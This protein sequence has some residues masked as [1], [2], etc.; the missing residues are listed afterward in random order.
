MDEFDDLIDMEL[1]LQQEECEEEQQNVPPPDDLQPPGSPSQ[2]EEPQRAQMTFIEEDEM[3]MAEVRQK[4]ENMDKIDTLVMLQTVYDTWFVE[5][6]DECLGDATDIIFRAFGVDQNFTLSLTQGGDFGFQDVIIQSRR[7]E[8]ETTGLF[9]QMRHL[10]IIKESDEDMMEDILTIEEEMDLRSR[11]NFT[12][13]LDSASLYGAIYAIVQRVS[14]ASKSI[15][16]K[17]N[18]MM[19]RSNTVDVASIGLDEELEKALQRVTQRFAWLGEKKITEQQELLIYLFDCAHDQCL[20]KMGDKVYKPISILGNLNTFAYEYMCSMNEFVTINCRRQAEFDQ[21]IRMTGKVNTKDFVVKQLID[22]ND[23]QFPNLQ[24]DR[25]VFSFKNGVYHC[26]DLKFYRFTGQGVDGDLQHIASKHF[27]LFF[28]PHDE[29]HDW[30]MIETPTLQYILE[31]QGIKDEVQDWMY[32]LLGRMLYNINEHDNWQCC[33]FLK[34][35]GGTGKSTLCN[36]VAKF[37]ESDQVGMLSNNIEKK[38]GLSGIMPPK[39]IFI[40]P[41]V[42]KDLALDQVSCCLYM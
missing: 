13:R 19:A 33:I 28:D 38:F 6:V 30:R 39:V 24:R 1:S 5:G 18:F 22:S 17:M 21:W 8:R 12:L 9:Y 2:Q 15:V 37:Y 20:R 34:G 29:T 40:A 3:C 36:L 42:K 41:E 25:R 35:S 32:I 4:F 10:N 23:Y 7:L 31:Y 14:Y 11:I 27:D 26:G 16:N